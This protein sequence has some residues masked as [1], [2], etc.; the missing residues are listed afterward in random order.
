MELLA[1][2][3]IIALLAAL[4][5]P[6]FIAIMRDRRVTQVAVSLAD[7]YREARSRSLARGIAVAVLW[8]SD[9]A[10]KGTIEIREA[11]VPVPGMGTAR[12]CHTADWTT[13]S[14]DT[15]MVT[16]QSFASTIYELA[17]IKLLSEGGLESPVGQICFAD[18]RAYARYSDS[19]V[20][21]SLAGVPRFVVT[22]TRTNVERTVFLPPNGVARLA[23]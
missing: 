2:I 4:A 3:V 11:I 15:R 23:L 5:T 22:N 9:G 14:I 7:T 17:G 12:S 20:F 8:Q 19:G 16:R 10:G 13:A 1:A 6:S 21:A 18:G